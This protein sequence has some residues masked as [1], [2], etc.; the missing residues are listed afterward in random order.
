MSVPQIPGVRIPSR[1]EQTIR[2]EVAS[3]LG[4]TSTN[5]P[6]AQ[7][8]SFA[9]HHLKE[10]AKKDYY[11]CEKTDGIRCLLYC[12][13]DENGAEVHYFINRKNEYYQVRG[14]H[15][16]HEGDPNFQRFHIA[17]ILDGELVN[18][19]YPDGSVQLRFYVF[20]CL[21][22][23]GKSLTSRILD[24]RLGYFHANIWVPYRKMY[25]VFPQEKEFRMME[26]VLKDLGK[27]Y[28]ITEAFNKI[29]DLKHGN[30]G[31][32]F[33]CK[34]TPYIFGT[35][36][37]ILKWKPPQENTV[38]FVL[39]VG[40]FPLFYSETS[41][42]PGMIPDYDDIPLLELC[43][44]YGNRDLRNYTELYVTWQEWEVMKSLNEILDDR[45]I[46]CYRDMEGR[47]RY[48]A[49]EDRRPRFR[50]DKSDA[51]HIST[52]I[53]VIESINDGVSTEDLL[54]AEF[55]IKKG[56]KLRHPEEDRKQ[57][58]VAAPA[59]AP[60]EER[61]KRAAT[62][63]PPSVQSPDEKKVKTQSAF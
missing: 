53:K 31:L 61:R 3:L 11:L 60:E 4:R 34:S 26:L 29:K 22:I 10:I 36:E 2:Q 13:Q 50:D 42:P 28:G 19:R 56:W 49:E 47:W 51:N 25:E 38:D 8:V 1:L 21:V 32:V 58:I 30:D 41:D 54:A 12:T 52:V 24:I 44:N 5:F 6:G 48:K 27:P 59:P 18:D 20:D 16:P 7:P 55:D 39:K 23:D 33:T 14:I 45:I 9:R 63:P 62:G 40:P 57:T 37:N 17:T 46:E 15:F 35:D 43:V